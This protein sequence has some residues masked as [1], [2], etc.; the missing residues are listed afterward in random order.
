MILQRSIG[1]NN[2]P[3]MDGGENIIRE[4]DVV[5]DQV[6]QQ[7]RDWPDK[8]VS[9]GWRRR[10]NKIVFARSGTEDDCRG[11]PHGEGVFSPIH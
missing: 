7:A 8:K 6:R 3:M 11:D 2:R 9:T 5:A 4:I 10:V 1:H